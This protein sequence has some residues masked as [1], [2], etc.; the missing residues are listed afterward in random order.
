[1][2]NSM[3]SPTAAYLTWLKANGANFEKLEF[4]DGIRLVSTR[5]LYYAFVLILLY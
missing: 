1:M 5:S 4:K 3:S 2:S